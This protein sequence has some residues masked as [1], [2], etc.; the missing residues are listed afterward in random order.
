M[1][2]QEISRI[3]CDINQRGISV[4]L[5]EQNARLALKLARYAYVLETGNIVMQ[6]E[7]AELMHSDHVRKAYL[8]K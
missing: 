7:A 1:N 4:I 6:G 2:V 8:G 5:V 3:V